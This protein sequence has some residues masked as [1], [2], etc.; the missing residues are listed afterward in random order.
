[1]P[2]NYAILSTYPPTQCGLA[3]FTAALRRHLPEPGDRALVV[4]VVDEQPVTASP[5]EV[6][7]DLI[8]G[9]VASGAAA[10]EAMNRFDA[11][12][13]QHEY[14]IY[15]GL[16]GEDLLPLLAAVG[17]PVIAVLHTVLAQP[18]P[19]QR[20]ILD[21]IVGGVAAVVTMT[22]TARD[23]AVAIY[24]ADPARVS[25]IPHGAVDN[26][27]AHSRPHERHTPTLL[28]WGLLGRGKG[29]EHAIEAVALLRDRGCEVRYV[30]AGQT[31]PRVLHREGEAYR[32]SL[33]AQVDACGAQDLVRFDNRFLDA[34]A[35]NSLIASADVVVLP[36]DSEEQVT[37]G[38][39]IEAVTA[40]KPVVSSCF[41]HAIELLGNGA[42]LLVR[43][44]DPEA[45]ANALMTVLTEPGVAAAMARES[46]RLAPGLLWP[47]VAESYRGLVA[48]VIPAAAGAFA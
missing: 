27:V 12:I 15:G 24:G 43:R 5:P 28:T 40:G 10:V 31:H 46:A 30:I 48:S 47:A 9:S 29:L 18:T 22:E 2:K 6:V 3:T 11:V 26:R 41:P 42:G 1:M 35:L 34:A 17:V 14:G 44:R 45:L 19:R 8:N 39:L 23:R 25:V 20:R 21:Q 4:R 33:L 37:S 32:S 38:V 13:V 7:C 36:Y 16:D